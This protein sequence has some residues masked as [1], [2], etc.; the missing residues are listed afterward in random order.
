MCDIHVPS[1]RDVWM[2]SYVHS[3]SLSRES[4]VYLGRYLPD[5]GSAVRVPLPG[6][7]EAV[8]DVQAKQ[9]RKARENSNG[10]P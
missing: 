8:G 9:T 10:S 7:G 3:S 5:S 1:K 2:L 6:Y 4:G